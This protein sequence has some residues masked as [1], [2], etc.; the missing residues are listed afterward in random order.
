MTSAFR[1]RL[2]IACALLSLA[3]APV[4]GQIADTA[5]VTVD[6]VVV[7][8]EAEPTLV[9]D[10]TVSLPI[11]PQGALLRSF[12]LP[13]WGQTAFESYV[14][15]GVYFAGWAANWFMIFRTQVRLTEARDKFDQRVAAI[16]TGLIENAPNPDSMAAF[17]DTVPSFLDE[18]VEADTGPGN[19][20]ES[21]GNL[22]DSREQQR[23]DWIAW[24]I[25]WVLA[26]G[27]DAFVTAH[28]ADF[29]AGIEVEP[30]PE[31]AV[32]LRFEVPLPSGR[33]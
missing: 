21:L 14:R 24:S 6:S 28:L 18:A 30:G 9:D 32:S 29:P 8:P 20:G 10:S 31:R 13:G 23:E 17:L 3:A 12:A 7:T 2:A 5:R 11:S 33:P 15:G 19:T 4:G 1:T 26:S 16:R 25:F 22:V 27:L